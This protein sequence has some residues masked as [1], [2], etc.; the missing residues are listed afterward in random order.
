MLDIFQ[1]HRAEVIPCFKRDL[2]RLGIQGDM[3]EA[4][5]NTTI[6]PLSWMMSLWCRRY[7]GGIFG[8]LDTADINNPHR[9]SAL[10]TGGTK[11]NKNDSSAI[12]AE[13]AILG[14]NRSSQYLYCKCRRDTCSFRTG[15]LNRRFRSRV[16]V[17]E[18]YKLFVSTASTAAESRTFLLLRLRLFPC[19]LAPSR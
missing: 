1:W 15:A 19:A 10:L 9:R 13:L 6:F 12:N 7:S 2:S 16:W 4:Y 11:F 18:L 3:L 8:P 14:I 5:R 17:S